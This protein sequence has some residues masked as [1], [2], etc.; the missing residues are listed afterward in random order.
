MAGGHLFD[1]IPSDGLGPAIGRDFINTWIGGRSAFSGGPA[2]WFDFD[3]YNAMLRQFSGYPDLPDLFWSYPPHLV[4]FVWP[5]GLL[6]YLPAYVLWCA[7]GLALYLWAALRRRREEAHAVSRR[8]AGCRGQRVFRSER[9]SDRG[10][11][12][13]RAHQS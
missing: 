1:V 13:R 10:A 12:D 8:R 6:P 11:L 3:T 2:P 9:L 7:G 5:L 4:L